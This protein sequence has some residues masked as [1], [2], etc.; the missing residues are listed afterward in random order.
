MIDN[1]RLTQQD[2]D[3]LYYHDTAIETKKK[4][5]CDEIVGQNTKDHCLSYFI[6]FDL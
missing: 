3:D 2:C 6:I 4:E 1:P 5:M